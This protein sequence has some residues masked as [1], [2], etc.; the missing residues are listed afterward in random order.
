M[1]RDKPLALLRH[2]DSNTIP[3]HNDN[4][5]GSEIESIE[6]CL[7]YAMEVYGGYDLRNKW[8]LTLEQ[9][10]EMTTRNCQSVADFIRSFEL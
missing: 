8:V 2:C 6:G 5:H 4:I 10:E 9:W 7:V 3:V 1:S